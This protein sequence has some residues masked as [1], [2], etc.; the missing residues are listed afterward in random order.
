MDIHEWPC[1]L[2]SARQKKRLVKTDRDKQLIRLDRRHKVLWDQ[3]AKLPWVP[4][5]EPYQRGW[6]RFF[7]L[8]EDVKHSP[9][10]EFYEA[11]LPKINT[12]EY[13]HD[14]SFKRKKR[15]KGKY[16]YVERKQTLREFDLYWWNSARLNLSEQEKACFTLIETFSI[17]TRRLEIK[18]VVT[19]Q[20][21]FVL[22]V[23]PN[24]ITHKK[25]K[26]SD[27]EKELAWIDNHIDRH[28]LAPRINL[29]TRGRGYRW[30]RWTC[31]RTKYINK[32]KN[33]PRYSPKEA[34]LDLE[35]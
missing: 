18:Y 2:K 8:R 11:L 14:K 22:K 6:K 12:V 33:I 25:L 32:I 34:Y 9:G 7:V 13:H 28:D 35:T 15:R 17:K 23:V 21:R 26:D 5:E 3:Q 30:N 4:L 10:A 31:A 19:E 1:R 27:I 24:M 20:W 29:L 16:G